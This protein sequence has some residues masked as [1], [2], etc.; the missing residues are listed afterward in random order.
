MRSQSQRLKQSRIIRP[1]DPMCVAHEGEASLGGRLYLTRST[2][3]ESG[4]NTA[5]PSAFVRTAYY[6]ELPT[7]DAW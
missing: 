5:P 3:A 4:L 2:A 1:C 6:K 7:T